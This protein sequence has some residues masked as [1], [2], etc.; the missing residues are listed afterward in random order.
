[1]K[2]LYTGVL[3]CLVA[4]SLVACNTEEVAEIAN[5]DELQAEEV[6]EEEVEIEEGENTEENKDEEEDGID[7]HHELPYEWAGSYDLEAGTYTLNFN[8][9]EHGD[10]SILIGYVLEDSNIKD[11]EHH[12]AHVMDDGGEEITSENF[13]ATSEYAYILSLNPNGET[14]YTFTI[15]VPGTYRIFTEHHAEEFL[16]Q[17]L[18][19]T[20]EEVVAQNPTD[21][22]GHNH[23]H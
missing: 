12:M 13:T 21:Y 19:E 23:D 3:S 16:L 6:G 22:E 7:H 8:K 18:I 15:E 4:G 17:V 2:K 14:T 11:L 1:M 9:N 20:G 10:E 5:P